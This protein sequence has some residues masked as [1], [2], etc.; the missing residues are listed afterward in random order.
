MISPIVNT[1]GC[2]QSH[3][4]RRKKIQRLWG[5]PLHHSEKFRKFSLDSMWHLE[6]SKNYWWGKKIQTLLN[7]KVQS[8]LLTLPA[9][10]LGKVL[11]EGR[12]IVSSRVLSCSEGQFLSATS[13]RPYH[14]PREGSTSTLLFSF[15][16]LIAV[17][18]P[19]GLP[20]L[21]KHLRQCGYHSHEAHPC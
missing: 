10:C 8:L 6:S 11:E 12:R 3:Q 4:E 21:V 15:N 5:R 7:W 1:L 2:N 9:A 20:P 14:L 13:F 17:P 19:S 18:N 16:P